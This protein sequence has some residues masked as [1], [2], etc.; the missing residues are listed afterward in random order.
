MLKKIISI[1]LVTLMLFMAIPVIVWA[2]AV[3][4][5]ES[6]FDTK[7]SETEYTADANVSAADLRVYYS[8]LFY[9]YDT[10]YFRSEYIKDY[11]RETYDVPFRIYNDYCEDPAFIAVGMKL[12]A[13]CFGKPKKLVDSYN[14]F[15]GDYDVTY[16]EALDAANLKMFEAF[17]D[18]EGS[19][20]T[21][22]G[23]KVMGSIKSL[24]AYVKEFR[25]N[26]YSKGFF[27]EYNDEEKFKRILEDFYLKGLATEVKESDFNMFVAKVGTNIDKYLKV[28]SFCSD[29]VDFCHVVYTGMILESARMEVIDY[30]IAASEPGSEL[31]DGMTRMKH[32]LRNGFVAY[33][34]DQYLSDKVLNELSNAVISYAW[35][36]SIPSYSFFAIV[37]NILSAIVFDQL[38]QVP[39]IDEIVTQS[40]LIAYTD[41]LYNLILNQYNGMYK[42]T[43]GSSFTYDD[44]QTFEYIFEMNAAATDALLEST[45]KLTLDFNKDILEECIEKYKY[46]SY[47]EYIWDIKLTIYHTPIEERKMKE[48]GTLIVSTP[49]ELS[50]ASDELKSGKLYMCQ[51]KLHTNVSITSTLTVPEDVHGVIDGTV[52]MGSTYHSLVVDGALEIT[53]NLNL[54]S[55]GA[56]QSKLVMND[57]ESVLYLGGNLN[58]DSFDGCRMSDGKIVFNGTTQQTVK[59]LKALDIEVTN[60]EGIKYLNNVYLYG[61]YDLNGNPLDS[62]NY[63]TYWYNG[64]TFTEGSDY[65]SLYIPYNES[66]TFTGSVKGNLKND[67]VLTV[68][69][70]KK[71][72]IIGSI[73]QSGGKKVLKIDGELEVTGGITLNSDGSGQSYI[74]MSEPDSVLYLGGNFYSDSYSGCQLSDGKIVFN[75][76]TQQTVNY[77]KAH[78]VEVTNPAG[79]KYLYHLYLYGNYDLNGNPLDSGN[80]YTYW[81]NGATFAEGDDYKNLYIPYNESVTLEGSVKGNV[82]NDGVLTVENGKKAKIIGSITQSGGR[83]VLK[84]NGELEVTGGITL[85]SDGSGQSYILMSEP[86]SVLY[87]GGNLNST[88]YS[89]C[90]ISNGKVIL[91]GKA[92]QTISYLATPTLILENTSVEGVKFNYGPRVTRLFD[93]KGNKFT[94]GYGC[95]FV[96]YDGDGI[97]DHLDPE[98]TVGPYTVPELSVD[99]YV[100]TITAASKIKD[101]RF[102]L[103][104]YTTPSEIKAAAG[105]VPLDNKEVKANTVDG[106]FVYNMP[107]GGIYTF[108]VRTTDGKEYFFTADMTKFIPEVNTY[109]VTVTVDNLY[110][111]R[112]FFISKGEFNSYDEIKDNGYIVR[113]TESKIE[114]KHSYGYTVKEPGMHTVLVRYNDGREYIFHEKLTVDEPI[115]TTN[116]LQVTV[117]NI[118]D[119]KVIRTAYGEYYTPGD[120]KRAV[121]AR[122][123]SNKSVIKDAE[124][125]MLQYRDEGIITVVVEYNNGY[126][127]V[128]HH[129]LEKKTAK[130]EQNA[131][132]VTF[133]ELDGLV[134]I[135]YVMGEYATSSEIK[136]A[137]GSKVIK[138]D[139]IVDGKITVADL[140]AGIYTFC[141]QYNDESYN[142][143]TITVE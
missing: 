128:F 71:A 68:E 118:P 82:K 130:I 6:I 45:K 107:D 63:Y 55:S 88:S 30:I 50:K 29:V 90:S 77:L 47:D 36:T 48:M 62:G 51:G 137:K 39:S 41:Q 135:R 78:N 85:N 84:I 9:G 58:C 28:A 67:G 5:T 98:P 127:K 121:G 96:D 34:I 142:Y 133:T 38:L 44:I 24:N 109:G 94:L 108:W 122:N 2:E 25:D 72:K 114:G 123:F 43:F 74:L 117:S 95:S 40:V 69:D 27:D 26:R 111:V 115:F 81:Y 86:D 13:E 59:Y 76:N 124:S 18:R 134:M 105:N 102:A 32:Q 17:F 1:L 113:V 4:K 53:G 119:V 49:T 103:G 139:S 83:K 14:T 60:P 131:D 140:A 97:L 112:D 54:N 99:N 126:V 19:V 66:V 120:T 57:P 80:Y 93:H 89:G 33:F 91:N 22:W 73:T 143:Y 46:V 8:D 3:E 21:G 100:V 92:L 75:G 65:K 42:D 70:G 110:D 129:E 12:G 87:L 132:T 37:T 10:S 116:G 16:Y 35:S 15:F 64:A 52:T 56:G 79:I 138:P 136:R 31:Y 7:E 106:R 20:Y 104:T 61:H 11:A 125:Y 141:V 101:I 23:K